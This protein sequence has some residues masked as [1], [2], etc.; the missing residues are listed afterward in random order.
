MSTVSM[1]LP[2][3]VDDNIRFFRKV[4]EERTLERFRTINGPET[5]KYGIT[6]RRK[7]PLSAYRD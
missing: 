4:L 2:L 5:T 1:L 7:I 3:V 6:R